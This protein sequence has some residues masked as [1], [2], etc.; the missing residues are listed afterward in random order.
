MF[1]CMRFLIWWVITNYLSYLYH[2]IYAIDANGSKASVEGFMLLMLLFHSIIERVL[3]IIPYQLVLICLLS[4]LPNGCF[5]NG[6]FML[7]H[8]LL[9]TILPLMLRSLVRLLT[10]L[11]AQPTASVSTLLYYSDLL[12]R[13]LN[14]ERL[15]RTE[16]LDRENYLFHFLINIM[17]CFW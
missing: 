16:F 8:A 1:L 12:P 7:L 4:T 11:M 10:S 15:V 3:S 13:N 14:L 17:R 2:I 9:Q 5:F 6:F